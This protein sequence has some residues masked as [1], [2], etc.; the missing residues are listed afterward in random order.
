M[1]VVAAQPKWPTFRWAIG[2]LRYYLVGATVAGI[3][4]VFAGLI[5]SIIHMAVVKTPAQ[6]EMPSILIEP[7]PPM[8]NE[9]PADA[10]SKALESKAWA[11]AVNSNDIQKYSSFIA[12]F[13]N[14]PREGE[15]KDRIR[16]LLAMQRLKA[17]GIAEKDRDDLSARMQLA[18]VD[19]DSSVQLVAQLL[20]NKNTDPQLLIEYNVAKG[21]ASRYPLGFALFFSNGSQLLS[22]QAVANTRVRFDPSN[23]KVT[24]QRAPDSKTM[25]VC[26]NLLPVSIDGKP[27]TNFRDV[28]FGGSEPIIH[29]VRIDNVSIDIEYLAATPRG[30]AW[31]IGMRP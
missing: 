23:L 28:C 8:L 22:Y 11:D 31:I 12:D 30:A 20:A 24:F 3:G 14:S 1:F 17:K 21:F 16:Y 27:M 5:L 29:A 18:D 15:A 26:L 2:E 10:V 19:A 4:A 13:P 9:L 6:T 7:T 25:R